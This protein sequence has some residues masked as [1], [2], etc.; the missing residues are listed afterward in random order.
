MSTPGYRPG[1]QLQHLVRAGQRAL[2]EAGFENARLD[3]DVLLMH[4]LGIDRVGLYLAYPDPP[5][6]DIPARYWHLIERRLSGEPVA[7]I[8]GR[9]EFMGHDFYVDRRVLIPR[10]ETE[11]L[12]EWAVQQLNELPGPRTIVDVGTGSGAIAVSLACA[13][14]RPDIR[15]LASD[16]SEDALEVARRNGERLAPG[17]VEFIQGSLLSWCREPLDLVLANLPY[18]RPDQAHAGIAWEPTMALYTGSDGL[19]L[20][21]ELLPQARD[22]LRDGGS[23]AF[24][25]DPAQADRA[26]ALTALVFPG[27]RL[28]VEPD[29]AGLERYVFIEGISI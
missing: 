20:Y 26:S 29:L 17:R 18:L 4:L 7:Y 1:D 5:E 23:I 6:P 22:T 11:R 24:E 13:L 21:E 10:P 27:A 25:I 16:V 15:I 12:V 14:E 9:R 28:R 3:A 19:E 8:I 2:E